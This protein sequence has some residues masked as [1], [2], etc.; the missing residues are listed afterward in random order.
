MYIN[1]YIDS[2]EIFVFPCANRG[3][4]TVEAGE[5]NPTPYSQLLTEYNLTHTNGIIGGFDSYIIKNVQ[6]N[7]AVKFIA[8]IGGYLFSIPNGLDTAYK[9]I[10]II[11]SSGETGRLQ[12]ITESGGTISGTDATLDDGGIFYGAKFLTMKPNDNANPYSYVL[13]IT[14]D[15]SAIA[16]Y[17]SNV[18]QLELN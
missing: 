12:K 5:I 13:D 9:Y 3:T 2:K 15:T 7:G 16:R 4:I 18:S 11:V 10:G 17:N 8:V 14:N 6:T 1:G